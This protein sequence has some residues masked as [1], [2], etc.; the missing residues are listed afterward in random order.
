M[1]N[2]ALG[3]GFDDFSDARTLSNRLKGGGQGLPGVAQVSEDETIN[4]IK[5]TLT[6]R[7]AGWI[8]WLLAILKRQWMYS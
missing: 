7:A 8:T 5:A 1:F 6:L 2:D 3:S 4:K